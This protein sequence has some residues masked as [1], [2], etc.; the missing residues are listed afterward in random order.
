MG[1]LVFL[2][3]HSIASAMLPLDLYLLGLLWACHV[4]FVYSIHISQYFCCVNSHAIMVSLL[5]IFGPYHSFGHL[6]P[7]LFL[8]SYGLLRHLFGF[9]SLITISFTFRGL[10]A[11]APTPFTNSFLWALPTRFACFPFLII[12]M[13]LL[14]ASLG[15]FGPVCF[16]W[17]LFIIIL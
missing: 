8:H 9:P 5:G 1:R 15:S 13:G 14:L 10:L 4:L 2:P 7:I 16:L 17:G 6:W 12:L 3:C 11:F